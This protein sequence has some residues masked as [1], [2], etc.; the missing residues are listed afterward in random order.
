MGLAALKKEMAEDYSRSER[1]IRDVTSR[2]DKDLK[3]ELRETAFNMWMACY[4]NQEIADAIGFSRPAVSEFV[5]SIPNVK[6]GTVADSDVSSENPQLANDADAREF[7][8]DEEADSNG[9]AR[10]LLEPT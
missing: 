6:N 10:V 5:N 4:D 1:H 9:L 2:I 7:D 8:E 3:V